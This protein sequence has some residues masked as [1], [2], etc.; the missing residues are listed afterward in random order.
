MAAKKRKARKSTPKKRA[1]AR[2]KHRK[3]PASG[4]ATAPKKRK[5]R[6][7]SKKRKAA[8]VPRSA[9]GV[10]KRSKAR[11]AK[12]VKVRGYRRR[13]GNPDMPAWALAG[14][15]AAAGLAAYA[16][17]GAGSFALTQ[18]LDPGM[19]SLERNRYIGGGLA[20]V[21]GLAI[22]AF[23]SPII[24]AGIAAGGLVGVAGTDLYLAL[25]K[26]LDKEPAKPAAAAPAPAAAPKAISGLFMNGQQQINGLFRDGQQQIGGLYRVGAGGLNRQYQ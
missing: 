15:A 7:A 10:R 22:A 3:A 16:I 14:L 9:P 12:T 8:R 20:L 23:A 26:V 24:G 25:G 4:A 17:T 18:R 2:K 1:G 6:S 5:K 21:A 11:R 19:A 13:K